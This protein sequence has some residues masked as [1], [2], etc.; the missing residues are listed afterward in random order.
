[1]SKKDKVKIQEA[2]TNAKNFG[3]IPA[4][5]VQLNVDVIYN[6][7]MDK[8][9]SVVPINSPNQIVSSL[10]LKYGSKNKAVKDSKDIINRTM[11]NTVGAMPLDLYGYTTD[12]VE[13]EATPLVNEDAGTISLIGNYKN[14]IPG[15]VNIADKYTD[16]SLGNLVDAEG[17]TAGT[18]DYEKALFTINNINSTDALL[19]KYKFDLV[20]LMTSRNMAYFEKSFNQ[21][22]A[23]QYQLDIDS[24]LVL[25]DMKE[26]DLKK[27]IENILP[28]VL[29]QQ[30]DGS[31]ISKYFDLADN[32]IIPVKSW[33]VKN[34]P[35]MYDL[36]YLGIVVDLER[37]RFAERTGV[38][39]NVII[40]DPMAYGVLSTNRHFEPIKDENCEF[41]GLPTKCVGYFNGS[42]V[43]VSQHITANTETAEEGTYSGT[44]ILTYNGPSDVQSAA[45]CA[46]YIPVTLRTEQGAEG[47]GMVINNTAYAMVGFVFNN[48]ELISGIRITDIK[49]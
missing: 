34:I 14:I 21:M 29:A 48:P 11:M 31:L 23:E 9:C 36:S 43:V 40:C 8:I 47:G 19:I 39:P 22:F 17:A 32:N 12:E 49:Y 20:N 30:I 16:D 41:S 3:Y 5:E 6:S 42:I 24:A 10:R 26:L 46:P 44:I 33:S 13:F 1:M 35:S 4:D 28:Q 37:G 27:N 45:I 38:I 15:T 2:I 25:N 7:I 18:V